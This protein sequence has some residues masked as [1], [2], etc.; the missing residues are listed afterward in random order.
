MSTGYSPA[1]PSADYFTRQAASKP[2]TPKP[3]LTTASSKPQASVCNN[4]ID[5][6]IS[7]L[8]AAAAAA[9]TKKRPPPPPKPKVHLVTALYDFQG[10]SE[11][12]LVFYEGDKIRVIEKTASLND[13]W[14]GELRGVKG[15]FPANYVE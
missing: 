13:W 7:S 14:Q 8:G 5:Q 2:T 3:T 6:R 4:S 12:D 15:Y 9:A 11:G 10:Q 1:G